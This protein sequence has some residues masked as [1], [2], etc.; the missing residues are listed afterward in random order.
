VT[1][2]HLVRHGQSTWNAARR[3]QGQTAHVELTALRLGHA[4]ADALRRKHVDAVYSSDLLR[5]VQTALPIA[6][7]L[8]QPIRRTPGPARALLRQVRGLDVR[9]RSGCD[10]RPRL[11]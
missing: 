10:F 6:A 7:A 5:A 1:R 8:R 11:D 4:A 3:L 9:G 2:P